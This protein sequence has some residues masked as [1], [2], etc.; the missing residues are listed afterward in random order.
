MITI[1]I[2]LVSCCS[3][4][5]CYLILNKRTLKKISKWPPTGN[6]KCGFLYHCMMI[7]DS[8]IIIILGIIENNAGIIHRMN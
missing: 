5:T 4:Y 2:C 3:I 7:A 8:I 1:S 6:S